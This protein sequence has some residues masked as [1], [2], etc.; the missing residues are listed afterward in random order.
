MRLSVAAVTHKKVKK[1]CSNF[2]SSLGW[3]TAVKCQMRSKWACGIRV[4]PWGFYFAEL[5]V[6]IYLKKHWL[7]VGPHLFRNSRSSRRIQ[8]EGRDENNASYFRSETI[9]TMIMKFT[10]FMDTSVIKLRC[11]GHMVCLLALSCRRTCSIFLFGRTLL[12][13]CFNFFTTCTHRC[14]IDFG[15]SLQEL[16]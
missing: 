5:W 11:C 2:R 1:G 10:C 8:Y 6:K 9:I 14:W 4:G 15:T 16:H 7:N 3:L 12:I 13:S